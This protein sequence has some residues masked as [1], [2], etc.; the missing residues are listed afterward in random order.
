MQFIALEEQITEGTAKSFNFIRDGETLEG[1]LVKVDGKLYAFVNQCKHLPLPLD[2]GDQH[3]LT[4]DKVYIICQNHG[5]LYDPHTGVCIAGP[6][7]G[8]KLDQLKIEVLDGKI[9]LV[10]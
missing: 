6:C 9:W 4:V 7:E 10:D 3:F 1:F 8:E 5:A 2:F